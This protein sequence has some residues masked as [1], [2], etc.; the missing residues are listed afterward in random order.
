MP[1]EK[2]NPMASSQ[3][4]DVRWWARNKNV[5]TRMQAY[6][7]PICLVPRITVIWRLGIQRSLPTWW[8][9]DGEQF[10]HGK[11]TSREGLATLIT[12]TRAA[13]ELDR[14]ANPR[15]ASNN[16]APRVKLKTWPGHTKLL[17]SPLRWKTRRTTGVQHCM[18]PSKLKG[19]DDTMT[20]YVNN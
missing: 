14:Y 20:Y 8:L 11:L 6:R 12:P 10:L 15:D 2:K 7:C 3:D 17:R 1:Q 18:R 5:N 4:G 19:K 9:V 13:T 16:S